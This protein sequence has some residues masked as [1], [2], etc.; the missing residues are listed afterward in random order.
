MRVLIGVGVAGALGAIAR[1]QLDG[2][3]SARGGLFPWGTFVI[4]V[5]GAFVLGFLFTV[6]GDRVGV[7]PWV[8]SALTIGFVGAYTTFSTLMLET[9]QLVQ[10]GA[11]SA[12]VLNAFG[13]LA[14]GMIA[15][16]AG[17]YLG[18]LV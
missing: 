10:L 4:N 5:S 15:V 14:C 9:A 16:F 13:S 12:A 17:I 18:R 1:Y 2:V 7:D 8:R 6:L 11:Y 3:I